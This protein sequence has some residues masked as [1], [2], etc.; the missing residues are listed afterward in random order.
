MLLRLA[1]A[2]A[3]WTRLAAA[4]DAAASP[5]LAAALRALLAAAPTPTATDK[6]GLAF[7]PQ[8]VGELQRVAAGI[9]LSLPASPAVHQ[10]DAGGWVAPAAERAAAVAAADALVRGHQRRRVA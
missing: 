8:Q 4:L 3:D 9:G 7:T 2:P 6:V 5:V 10:P 1:A